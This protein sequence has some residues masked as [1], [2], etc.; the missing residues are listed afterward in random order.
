MK[1]IKLLVKRYFDWFFRNDAD[2]YKPYQSK[3]L[4]N[5]LRSK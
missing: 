1:L 4:G 5:K 2:Y 3:V